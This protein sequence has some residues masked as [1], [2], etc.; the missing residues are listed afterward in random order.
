MDLDAHLSRG[1]PRMLSEEEGKSAGAV[2]NVE[3]ATHSVEPLRL[4][5]HL[6]VLM[7]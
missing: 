4:G 6:P 2:A 3:Q 1:L 7:I 5:W